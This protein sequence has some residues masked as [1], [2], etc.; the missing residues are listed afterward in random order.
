MK[1]SRN[2]RRPEAAEEDSV[3]ELGITQGIID[4]AREAAVAAGA[5]KVT[6]LY[7]AMTPAADFTQE[8]IAMYFEI[9]A[10]EDELFTGA[11]LHFSDE[12]AE[13]ACLA[14]QT[15]FETAAREPA[16]PNCGSFQVS[17]SPR[18]LMIRLTD[19]GIDDGEP[20]ES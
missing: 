4:R 20:A 16:C 10:G 17:F 11:S 3:H 13:A 8:S 12:P 18:A 9:L 1:V 7:I 6:D 19:I 15:E 14:C 5:R 2:R